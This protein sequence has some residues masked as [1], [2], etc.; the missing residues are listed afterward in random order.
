M[1]V[2]YFKFLKECRKLD[3]ITILHYIH[4]E[5]RDYAYDFIYYLLQARHLVK[6][7]EDICKNPLESI[8]LKLL[9]NSIY[10]QFLMEICK[11]FRYTYVSDTSLK[12]NSMQKACDVNLITIIPKKNKK[13][14]KEFSMIFQA[15]YDQKN[16]KIKNLIQLGAMILGHSRV[17]FY[18][19]LYTLYKYLE[20]SMA[21]NCYIDT[22]SM[23]WALGDSNLKNC[24]KKNL[25]SEFENKTKDMFVNPDAK[26]TQAGRL[27]LEGFFAAGYFK[28]VKNYTL[29]PFK[30][31]KL[32]SVNKAKG[33][34]QFISSK[35]KKD[36]FMT[37]S[38]EAEKLFFQSYKLH[39]TIG[40]EQIFISLQK[41]KM[42]NALNCKR[43]IIYETDVQ[44]P[45]RVSIKYNIYI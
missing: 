40:G 22:D 14:K 42:T 20:P 5:N 37:D 8:T 33:M 3:N 16:A 19:Q 24:V 30:D 39:P 35:M 44:Y 45:D 15:K 9:A 2:P 23:M 36:H 41:R 31:S 34:P 32:E 21:E 18:R 6:M 26:V 27:K 7:M 25:L 4:Y 17:I 28:C 29:I 12:K 13:N 43:K 38:F 1:P 10:G 11:Y